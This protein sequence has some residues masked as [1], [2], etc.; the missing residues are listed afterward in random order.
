MEQIISSND[1]KNY[2]YDK[3]NEIENTSVIVDF[4]LSNEINYSKNQ[5]GMHINISVL[6]DDLINELYSIIQL[7][8]SNSYNE[9]EYLEKYNYQKNQFQNKTCKNTEKEKQYEP[10]KL[11]NLQVEL[12]ATLN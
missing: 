5:N 10:L 7:S 12:L 1:K 8:I 3:I 2:I 6:S 9:I 4:I 11:T